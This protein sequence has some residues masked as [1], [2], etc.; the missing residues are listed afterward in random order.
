MNIFSEYF[1]DLPGAS[2][3]FSSAPNY[4]LPGACCFALST[5]LVLEIL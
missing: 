2:L 4:L 5:F 3:N 1:W